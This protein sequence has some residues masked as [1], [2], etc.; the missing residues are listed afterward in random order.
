LIL[1]ELL[2]VAEKGLRLRNI[3]EKD[4]KK[5]LG[6]IEKR[7]MKYM[8]GARWQLR[9]FT[10]LKEKATDDQALSILTAAM[11]EN[12]KNNIPVSDWPIPKYK[13]LI[14]YKPSK[15]L[16]S[17][18]MQTDLLTVHDDD[19]IEFVADLLVWKKMNFAL[20]EDDIGNLVGVVNIK[21]IL[22]HLVKS[23]NLK[24]DGEFL[25]VKDIM[26]KEPIVISPDDTIDVAVNL[27]LKNEIQNLP[28][29]KNNELIGVI[30]PEDFL[31]ITSNLILKLGE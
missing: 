10:K 2:P 6:I 3:N 26:I 11:I 20:V 30:T 13:E 5:Y 28:V 19:I 31:K 23:K 1:D 9:A 17:E 14:K 16:V 4:I 7:A 24:K 22:E 21:N 18:F 25:L 27:I 12:Q 8:N 15:L 29:V